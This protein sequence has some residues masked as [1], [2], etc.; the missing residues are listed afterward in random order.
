MKKY[1]GMYKTYFTANT[2]KEASILADA[3]YSS[4]SSISSDLKIGKHPAFIVYCDELLNELQAI[5]NMNL[6]ICILAKALPTVALQ[7]FI[8]QAVIEEIHQTNEMENIHSTKKEIQDEIRVVQ[9]GKK[10]RRF[11]GM[12]RKYQL[13]LDNKKIPL[14]SCQ[15]I[16]NLY[17]SFIW[18]EVA[19]EDPTDTP[20]GLYFRKGP[21]S[22][23][24]RENTIHMGVFPENVLNEAMEHALLLLND[25]DYDPLIRIAAFHYLFG[26]IHPFYNGNGRMTRFISSY[27]LSAEKIHH[28]ISLRLSY[29]IKSHKAQYYR[30]F[31]T[32]NDPRNYGDMTCF[33]IEFLRFVHEACEQV[34]VFLQEKDR[35][36]DHY[37]E[38][39][40]Q[41]KLDGKSKQLLFILA[42]V[43]ICESDSL[44]PRDIMNITKLSSYLLKKYLTKIESYLIISKAGK[45]FA[46]RADLEKLDT[47]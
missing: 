30:I 23:V 9:N 42:Q 18:E 11:D 16:R 24:R 1:E 19:K 31:K 44:L 27:C 7:Q 47:L 38:I 6:D 32:T 40:G 28:L 46:Y 29:V 15:D 21:V 36:L 14:Q 8:N 33:V 13:L 34:L 45:T 39:I 10:G 20:D 41:T 4:T 12:I 17:D 37:D 26:Y 3:L 25:N 35:L 43:S 5:R 2:K 22:V